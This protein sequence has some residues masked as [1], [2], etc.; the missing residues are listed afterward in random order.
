MTRR[1]PTGPTRERLSVEE[2]VKLAKLLDVEE[3]LA[4][5]FKDMRKA[6]KHI[7]LD[8]S[9]TLNKRELKQAIEMMNIAMT[10]E[11]FDYFWQSWGDADGSGEVDYEEFCSGLMAKRDDTMR[12][13]RKF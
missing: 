4:A 9:G 10:N 8:G 2:E 3:K 6:F 7:D 12:A 1:A 5:R 11:Q 13:V